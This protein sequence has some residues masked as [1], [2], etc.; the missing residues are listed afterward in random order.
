MRS[1]SRGLSKPE[2]RRVMPKRTRQVPLP[3]D[4]PRKKAHIEEKKTYK[5]PLE[6]REVLEE[7]KPDKKLKR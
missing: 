7:E 1:V 3:D 5:R 4:P 6:D 2:Y